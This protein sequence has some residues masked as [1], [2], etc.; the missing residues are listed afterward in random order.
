V[1]SRGDLTGRVLTITRGVSVNEIGP[2]KSGQPRPLTLGTSTVALWH[3]LGAQWQSRLPAG[4]TLGPWV[5][6][7]HGAHQRRLSVSVFDHRFRP[8]RDE[9]HVLGA[10]L[11]RLRHSVATFLVNRGEILQA[12]ARLGHSDPA[13]TLRIYAHAL[14]L[15]DTNVADAIN[16]Q[17]D[18]PPTDT[19]TTSSDPIDDHPESN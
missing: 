8:I 12:Q 17:L 10:S 5:F 3:V 13:T 16:Q 2:T 6:A 1:R 15:S 11:H 9:A 14:P 18:Q 19:E 4:C 7:A